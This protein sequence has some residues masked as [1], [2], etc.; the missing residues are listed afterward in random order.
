MI[1]GFINNLVQAG[2]QKRAAKKINPVNATYTENQNIKELAAEGENLYKGRMSGATQAEQNILSGA[3]N[4]NAAIDRNATSGSQ[5]IAAKAA[6]LGQVGQDF[7][8]L[9][10]KEAQ[11]KQGRFGIY[12]QTSQLMAQE[13]DKVFQDKLRK[14]YDDLNYKRALEGASMQNKANAWGS[15]DNAV[16]GAA[17]MLAPGGVLGGLGGKIFGSNAGTPQM[18]GGGGGGSYG[19]YRPTYPKYNP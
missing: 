14:Y 3:A 6:G 2:K 10:L 19:G 15:L 9:A 12:S 16:M 18:P 1:F 11:D 7:Q 13:G 5:A 17:T 8:D 4:Y